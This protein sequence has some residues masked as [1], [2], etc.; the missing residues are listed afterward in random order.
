MIEEL[1]VGAQFKL[2]YIHMVVNNSYLGLIRQAQRGFEMDYCVQLGFDNI[3]APASSRATASTTWRWSRAWAA[4]RS[5]CTSRK[6]SA[7]AIR[8]GRGL[9]GRVPGAGGDRGD[10][11]ARHQHLDGH[12]DRQRSTS[13]RSSRDSAGDAPTAIAH[14]RL[15]ETATQRRPTMP[16]FAANL[17][18]LFN[19][20]PFLDR[21]ERPRRPASTASS[22]CSPMRTRRRDQRRGSTRN[23]LQLVLH[24]LPAGDWDAGERGIACLPDR[25]ERVPRRRG[26]R[27]S[28]TPRRSACTQLNC[29]AGKAPAG[30]DATRLRETFV[31]NLRYAAGRAEEGRHPA[32]DRADQ[33]LRHPRLLPEP[34]ARR[35]WRSSTRSARDN[36][37]LQYDIYHAQRMEGELA[38]TLRSEPRAHRPHA[39]RRQPGPPRAGHRRDQLR[40]PVRAPRPHRLRAAGSAASTSRRPTTEAGLG[41]L[42]RKRAA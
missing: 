2:P 33:H 17:T 4:R 7:A 1:A 38:A 6:R 13:S 37:F 20:L 41:W 15:T 35:R 9:D 27:R 39:A 3:N 8:A 10:A 18:M 16:R 23:G 32:A 21:F 14:A 26:A 25:V 22:S 34:H 24:N 31:A 42:R 29:L 11:R 30:V 5:A 40:L 19:E 28:S 12:R 36:L